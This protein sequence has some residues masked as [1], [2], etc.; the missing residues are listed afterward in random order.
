LILH[1]IPQVAFAGRSNVGKSSLLNR[2]FNRKRLAKVSQTPG[3][4]QSIN[5]FLVDGQIHFVD[6]PGFG[7]AKASHGERRRWQEL[8][9]YYFTH[10]ESLLGMVHLIDIRHDPTSLDQSLREWTDELVRHRLYV[11]TKS[12]K[13][14]FSHR[15]QAE[16]KLASRFGIGKENIVSF[17]AVD[18]TGKQEI[19]TWIAGLSAKAV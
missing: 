1:G 10:S 13:V 19:L 15:R 18:G 2:L 7:Y 12:D 11:L 8:V 3:K 6:L 5:Y 17:S 4:T 14:K 16:V 9:E